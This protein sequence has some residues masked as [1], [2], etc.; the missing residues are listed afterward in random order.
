ASLTR[1]DQLP[2]VLEGI[3]A[4]KAAGLK[5]KLNTV[6]LKG[7]NEAEIPAL[8]AWAHAQ[9]HSVTLIEVMPLGEIDG[10]RFDHYLPL[11]A[12]RRD[13]EARW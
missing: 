4:A 13:L 1:R 8:I 5:V 9:G 11:D 3:A 2:Q 12:V 6:A 10:D 7:L